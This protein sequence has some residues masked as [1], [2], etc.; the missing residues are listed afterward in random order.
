MSKESKYS[1]DRSITNMRNKDRP[2]LQIYQPGKRRT[3]SSSTTP[4]D[5]KCEGKFM[6]TQ[7]NDF[8]DCEM[9]A[10]TEIAQST[11]AVK[12]GERKRS[13][14]KESSKNQ[15]DDRGKKPANEKRISRYSEKRNKAKEKRD[16]TDNP[17]VAS[18]CNSNSSIRENNDDELS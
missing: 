8:D 17:V 9:E 14:A 6:Y 5:E 7:E 18:D 3:N 2:S 4:T 12:N 1:K 10:N 13:D 16:L 15:S 11:S